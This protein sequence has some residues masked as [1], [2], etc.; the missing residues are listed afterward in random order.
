MEQAAHAEVDVEGALREG[1]RDLRNR[2]VFTIDPQDARDYD[3][4]IS[5]ERGEGGTW[6]L[7]VHIADV[8][9]YVEWGGSI[10]LD[11]R[12]RATSVYLVDRVL[13]MLPPRL[14]DDVCSLVPGSPR[15]TFT[16]DM[17]L[18]AD[19]DIL[20]WE[21]YPSV[22]ESKARLDYGQAQRIIE[23]G[24]SALAVGE[25]VM[26]VDAA[27]AREGAGCCAEA[28]LRHLTTALHELDSLAALRI[29][30]RQMRGGIDFETVE[31]KVVLDDQAHP[32]D[33]HLRQKTRATSVVEEA[34]LAANEC[35]ARQLLA[36]GVPALFRVHDAPLPDS[37]AQVMPIL[38]EFG[39]DRHVSMERFILG[40][41]RAVQD[42]LAH[43]EGRLESRLVS[44]LVLR[45]M[46]RAVYCDTCRA[47]YALAS[48]AYCHF[49]SPI[50]R[51]PDLVVHRMLKAALL[52]RP[53]TFD[54]QVESLAW[55][56][57]HCSRMERV[58]EDAARQ[59]QDMKLVEY[60]RQYVGCT[61]PGVIVGIASYGIYVQ[62]QNTAEGLVPVRCLGREPF[63]HDPA[64]YLLRGSDSGVEYR[65]GQCL[66]VVVEDAP[67]HSRRLE[68]RLA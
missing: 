35:A 7:G 67:L 4:A 26:A 10:D 61:F 46:Q 54:Q 1:Y 36:S 27:H 13:P 20:S 14:S 62:L 59:T 42:V 56:A 5:L 12:R 16:A 29:A 22:I 24:S 50:R 37:M 8:S 41:P 21:F 2:F 49:T 19:G 55:L 53:E 64:M 48:D 39:Y 60:M 44:Q 51:Y 40:D 9:H 11:A 57:E 68:L 52:G 63:A 30:L 23:G 58:A 45:C 65:L 17:V 47:H 25:L 3:D 32:V 6:L 28:I 18:D 34:M 31:A 15:R 43:A 33:V 38:Q 66:D